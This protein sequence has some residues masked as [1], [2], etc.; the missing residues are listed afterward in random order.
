MTTNQ[1]ETLYDTTLNKFAFDV[2]AV[3]SEEANRGHILQLRDY[4]L[5]IEE[6]IFNADFGDAF[7][8]EN[9]RLLVC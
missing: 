1:G 9:E 7:E 5:D 3:D 4:L 2:D 6:R 8:D